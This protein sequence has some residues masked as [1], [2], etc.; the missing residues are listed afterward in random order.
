MIISPPFLLARNAN[1]TD[2][3][4][5]NRCMTGGQPGDGAFPLS[6]A[7]QW[8]GG[9][10]LT[11][12]E[13]HAPVRAIA[14][15]DVVYWRDPTES[16]SGPLPSEH[17]QAYRGG[18]TDN[19]VIVLRHQTEIG[20]G[21]NANVTFFSIYMHLR[22]IETT[23][24]P[25]RRIDRKAAMGLAG[26]VYGQSGKL[27]FEIVCD[28]ANVARLAGRA[29]GELNTATDGRTDAVYG[30]MYFHLPPGTLVFGEKPMPNNAVAHR[31]P[32][33]APRQPASAPLPPPVA[34]QPIH[35]TTDALLIGLRYAGGD[36]A[37]GNRGD[38]HLSTYQPDGTQIGTALE[39]NDAEYDLYTSA[40]SISSA[41]PANARP[42][43]SA[44]YELLRFGR[45]IGPDALNPAN[46][47]H[48]RQIRHA[49]G[50]GWVNLNATGINKFSDADF[51]HWRGWTL[52]D[53]SADRDSRCDSITVKGWLDA[54]ADGKVTPAEAAARM[55][56]PQ[57]ANKLARAI[58]KIPTEWDA[59]TFDARLGWLKTPTLE[60]PTALDAANFE[61]L[62][63]HVQALAFWPGG[64]GLS[65]N[66]WH[67]QPKAF[68]GHFRQCGWLSTNEMAQCFPRDLKHLTGTHFV[69]HSF[70]WADASAR[71]TTWSLHF[72]KANRKYGI[73]QRQRL[74]HYF[75][76][77]VPETGYM[78]LMKESD[79][80]DGSYLRGKPYYPYYGRG[81][82]QLT[83]A[84]N[85]KR[86]GQFRGFRITEVNP[87]TYHEAGWNVDTL[88]VTNDSSY[89]AANCADSAGYYVAGYAGM[90]KKMD[91][92]TSADDC[93]AVSRCVN[94]NV[95]VQNINGLD[96][97]LQSV[98]IIRDV[99]L[100]LIAGAVSEIVRFT[101]RRNSQQE[102]TGKLSKAGKPI[103]AYIA[104]E[105]ELEVSLAKQRPR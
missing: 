52:V 76:Q 92:G 68:I 89:N 87:A 13:A 32:P 103:K 9:M 24:R 29:S 90:I 59:A 53:D 105:W 85:Y 21:A 58:C 1:E 78:R 50:T 3:A 5:I 33:R 47:P 6:H 22:Q 96:G 40:T 62:R 18:W 94:G 51:P 98:L 63:A 86:F 46:V 88:L 16:P 81:L 8:H 25:G 100:D 69:T 75:A 54:S 43:P 77:V 49:G 84:E 48:W 11:E 34:L 55:V 28:D 45:V 10:H 30:D 15:G 67:W 93:I 79:S 66:H 95:A 91:E 4:W 37:A 97:R 17:P 7:M 2:E 64:M 20:E 61:R 72:N 19:G 14:D 101:W 35:T 57:V 60:N 70:A 12:P 82:I 99:L 39:E 36:G 23:V 80:R 27:H 56:Q 102:A 65:E 73:D 26:E 74:V 83:W 42:A 44:V 104:R 38:A 41:Y 31:Q 71:S